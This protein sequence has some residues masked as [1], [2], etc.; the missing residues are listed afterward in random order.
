MAGRVSPSA[1]AGD[2]DGVSNGVPQTSAETP[3]DGC[4]T[5]QVSGEI[6]LPGSGPDSATGLKAYHHRSEQTGSE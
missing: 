2:P 3:T 6:Y 4:L 1:S 5:A